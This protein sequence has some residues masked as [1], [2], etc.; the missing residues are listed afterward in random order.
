[1][2]KKLIFTFCLVILSLT[3]LFFALS[4]CG[5]GIK[6][7]KATYYCPMHP[8]YT[9]D[10]PGD[11]PICNMKLVKREQEQK[12]QDTSHKPQVEEKALEEVCVEH[13]CTM[14][15]CTMQVKANL[16]PGERVS[17]PICGEYI[18]A[19]TGKLVKIAAEKEH[20]ESH[21]AA[22][23]MISPERQQLIGIKTEPVEKARLTKDIYASGKIAY[24]PELVVTQEEFINALKNEENVKSSP[25][26]DVV[27][28]AKTMTEAAR[29]KLHLLGMGEDQIVDLEKNQKPD[30]SLYLPKEGE[31]VWAYISVY[32]YEIGNVQKDAAVEIE[33]PAY[34]GEKFE[35]VVR[36]VNPVLDAP[37]RTN[38]VRV[39]VVNP[40]NKLKPEM[41]ANARIK[42]DLG[43][44]LA[45]PEGA[46]LDTGIRKIVYL[47]RPEGVLESR[48]VKLG[49]KAGGYYEVLG[50]LKEGDVVVTSGNFLVDS[51]SKL[52]SALGSGEHKH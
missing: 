38:Q 41:F 17:C 30:T 50:G 16:M 18:T 24:D 4:G 48:E 8:T 29:R 37:T 20:T 3:F 47:S 15:H 14:P 43:E 7:E 23:V 12:A 42:I 27:D 31:N 2:N 44:K 25:L 46:V 9:S 32:E 34:P 10:R 21:A 28:R 1:M 35:G 5:K 11:C 51:E 40:G 39:E 33:A 49:Q 19:A 52:K 13:A 22:T 6:G 26:K 36:S 45:V